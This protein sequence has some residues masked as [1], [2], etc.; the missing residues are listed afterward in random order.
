M[1][2]KSR[3]SVSRW[4]RK[5]L[6]ITT[7]SVA[8]NLYWIFKKPSIEAWGFRVRMIRLSVVLTAHIRTSVLPSKT[9]ADFRKYEGSSNLCARLSTS[10]QGLS[11]LFFVV[12]DREPARSYGEYH[13]KMHPY[14][15]STSFPPSKV[16]SSSSF[17]S[18]P[19]SLYRSIKPETTLQPLSLFFLKRSQPEIRV[20]LR[21]RRQSFDCRFE[22][23]LL[24][25]VVS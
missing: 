18:N 11:F 8:R 7:L 20:T 3:N 19:V 10:S 4:S 25:H 17:R 5:R 9:T 12:S 15:Y 14:S 22:N 23:I 24:F 13:H 6:I 16:T 2:C 21:V 1:R